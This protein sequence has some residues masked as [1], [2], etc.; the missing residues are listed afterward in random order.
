MLAATAIRNSDLEVNVQI[1]ADHLRIRY[2]RSNECLSAACLTILRFTNYLSYTY[3]FAYKIQ[4]AMQ[5]NRSI[6][7]PEDRNKETEPPDLSPVSV[8][9]W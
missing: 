5:K 7:V 4:K 2:T 1:I 8:H 9:R 6:L 3:P